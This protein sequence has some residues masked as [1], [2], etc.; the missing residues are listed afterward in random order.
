MANQNSGV[1]ERLL[2]A[3]E[4]DRKRQREA[5]YSDQLRQQRMAGED[6]QRQADNEPKSL[7]EQLAV[8]KALDIKRQVGDKLKEKVA[9]PAKLGT[10]WLLRVAWWL[11]MGYITFIPGVLLADLHV[12]GRMTL[13]KK[14]FCDLGDE[15]PGSK[16]VNAIGP[17]KLFK[18]L[19]EKMGLAVANFI[20]LFIII[21]ILA[22]LAWFYNNLIYK[23]GEWIFSITD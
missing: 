22:I 9:A 15:W 8:A 19:G 16:M 18:S 7:R 3:Q 20:T 17:A 6:K 11:M 5:A 13:G 1:D 4:A 14:F 23:A 12:F 21:A 10:D 2:A